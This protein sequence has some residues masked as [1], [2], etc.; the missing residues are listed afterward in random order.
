MVIS[1]WIS[2]GGGGEVGKRRRGGG[3]GAAERSADETTCQS[4][5]GHAL[6]ERREHGRRLPRVVAGQDV[7]SL[8]AVLDPLQQMLFPDAI[9]ER[10]R[11]VTGQ[12]LVES[13]GD[14]L[15]RHR[16][17]LEQ[18]GLHRSG[19]GEV[20]ERGVHDALAALAAL[21]EL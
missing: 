5:R 13:G 3:F 10:V 8:G 6:K 20:A 12:R 18:E 19:L 14:A 4:P 21:R 9:S 16:A 2:F 15:R 7:H 17:A 1:V 11:A